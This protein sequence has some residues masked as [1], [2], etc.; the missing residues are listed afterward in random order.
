ML[1]SFSGRVN[2]AYFT[3]SHVKKITSTSG[4]MQNA[5]SLCLTSLLQ[6][7]LKGH[8]HNPEPA[9]SKALSYLLDELHLND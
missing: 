3:P 9:Y 5:F 6:P 2:A 4:L 8:D 1:P 7:A